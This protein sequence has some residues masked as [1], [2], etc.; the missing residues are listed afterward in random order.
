MANFSVTSLK[1]PTAAKHLAIALA[2]ACYSDE[3]R[4]HLAREILATL[5]PSL[6]RSVALEAT[7]KLVTA[8]DRQY[9]D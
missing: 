9:Q 1:T 4:A 2:E 7:G 5:Q 6:E 8:Y 3:I